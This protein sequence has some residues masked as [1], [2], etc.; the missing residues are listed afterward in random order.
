MERRRS[1]Y[2]RG[3]FIQDNKFVEDYLQSPLVRFETCG[4]R[5]LQPRQSAHAHRGVVT[6]VV[7]GV[8]PTQVRR[9]CSR[10]ACL[11]I[12]RRPYDRRR[13]YIAARCPYRSPITDHQSPITRESRTGS[14]PRSRTSSRGRHGPRR[15][16]W[17]WSSCGCCR[18]RRSSSSSRRCRWGSCR[19][20]CY[21][22]CGGWRR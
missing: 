2:A 14:R 22:R 13:R 1:V 16:C 9:Y 12:R 3:P 10:H 8:S 20:W 18:S 7:A 17:P 6:T 4:M 19:R 5:L 21:C 11:Y 15:G